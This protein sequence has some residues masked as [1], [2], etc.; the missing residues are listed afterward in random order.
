MAVL[1]ILAWPDERLTLTCSPVAELATV[2]TLAADMLETMYAAKGR[3]LAAPQVGALCR[4][5]VMDIGWKE[6]RSDP[7]VMIN[8]M[9]QEVGEESALSTE[10]CLSIPGV[11][12]EVRRPTTVQMLWTSLQGA[13]V[14]QGFSGFGSVCVQHELDHLDGV[15]TL[16]HLDKETRAT[17]EAEYKMIRA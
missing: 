9:L 15:V 12:T 16:D 3:G 7:L 17:V 14:V 2:Q 1:S 8:P 6:G 11:T 5:F 4:M 13:R 10:G